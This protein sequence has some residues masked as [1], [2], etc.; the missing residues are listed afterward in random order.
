MKKWSYI[1]I[2]ELLVLLVFILSS[3]GKPNVLPTILKVTVIDNLG[4]FV[5][6]AVVTVYG[7]EEDYNSDSNPLAGPVKTDK[8]G[9]VTFKGLAPQSY[10]VDAKSRD[11]SN[12]GEGVKTAILK[13]GR[14]NKVNTV[15]L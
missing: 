5:E 2:I 15:I 8:K 10:Y 13:E 9:R 4:N 12:M 1:P 11:K 3:Y 7:S 14:I 6:G